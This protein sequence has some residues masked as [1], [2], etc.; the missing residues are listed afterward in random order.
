MKP[1]HVIQRYDKKKFPVHIHSIN[2]NHNADGL[3]YCTFISDINN[4]HSIEIEK[5]LKPERMVEVM[6]EEVCHAFFKDEPEY[7]VRKFSKELGKLL[8]KKF[9]IIN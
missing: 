9:D 4:T 2:K 5:D 6:I 7:K 8:I 1:Y 3:C